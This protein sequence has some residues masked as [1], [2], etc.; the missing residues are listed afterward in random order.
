MAEKKR[1]PKEIHVE[2]LIIK[3]NEVIIQDEGSKSQQPQEERRPF[4]DP[5]GFR[6]RRQQEVATEEADETATDTEEVNE[7]DQSTEEENVEQPQQRRPFS[8]F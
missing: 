3:A 6:P 1:K 7:D 8:W 5:W 4:R 2:N